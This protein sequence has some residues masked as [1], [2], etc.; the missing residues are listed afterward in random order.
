[1][2]LEMDYLRSLLFARTSIPTLEISTIV[3]VIYERKFLYP[4]KIL[5]LVSIF[6]TCSTKLHEINTYIEQPN[7]SRIRLIIHTKYAWKPTKCH[8][9]SWKLTLFFSYKYE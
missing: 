1:M 8:Q 3:N 9:N 5:R 6:T 7:V 4:L 2:F